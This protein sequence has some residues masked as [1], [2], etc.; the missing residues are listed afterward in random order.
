MKLKYSFEE[1]DMGEEIISV[2]VGKGAEEIHGVLKLNQEGKEILNLLKDNITEEKIV[3]SLC[4]K[5][6]NDY[7]TLKG[8]VKQ[9]I[10]TLRKANLIEE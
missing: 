4:N 7:E 6:D 9:V 8:Y 1:V 2:P 5:Y 3:E 10:N